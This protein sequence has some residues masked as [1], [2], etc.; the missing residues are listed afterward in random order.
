MKDCARAHPMISTD[1][2]IFGGI[3]HLR[4]MRLSVGDI[5]A[6]IYALGSIT[7]VVNYYA[8]YISE[9]QVKEAVAYAQDFLETTCDPHQADG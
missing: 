6:Q 5:L 8:P 1:E 4:E 2:G 9:E 7:A 3:P